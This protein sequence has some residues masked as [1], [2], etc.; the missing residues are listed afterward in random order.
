MFRG[1]DCCSLA[2]T[3]GAGM[4]LRPIILLHSTRRECKLGLMSLNKY[5]LS[6]VMGFLHEEEVGWQ[7]ILPSSTAMKDF[8][9]PTSIPSPLLLPP[10]VISE[11]HNSL[12]SF[13]SGSLVFLCLGTLLWGLMFS[14]LFSHF[15][16][17]FHL[18]LSCC[19]HSVEASRREKGKEG[20]T[21]GAAPSLSPPLS[22]SLSPDDTTLVLV[23]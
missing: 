15:F 13:S 12:F 18:T 6:L 19:T 22:L 20:V 7:A 8:V 9:A 4:S 11:L 14:S 16:F 1:K 3:I 5:N 23:C 21:D 10:S 17:C 2:I